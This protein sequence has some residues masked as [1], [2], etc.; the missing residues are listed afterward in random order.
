M[1]RYAR[2]LI[3]IVI[4]FGC[5]K[6]SVNPVIQNPTS[7]ILRKETWTGPT[8]NGESFAYFYNSS[9]LVERIERYQWGTYSANGGPTQTWFDTAYYTFEYQNG[10]CAKWSM[11]EGGACG[12]LVYEYNKRNLPVKR[13]LYYCNNVPESFTFYKYDNA[14]K[15]IERVDSSTAVD[16]RY[17]FTY[18]SETNLVAAICYILWSSPQQKMKYDWSN[19]DGKVNFIKAVNGLPPTF[20]WDNDF[21]SYSSSSPNN[22]QSEN[23]FTPVSINDSFGSPNSTN[24]SYQYNDAGLPVKM[25]SGPWTVSFEYEKYK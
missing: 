2:F 24:Y 9:H 16:F 13:T 6:D 12:F 1:S 22:S 7:Y 17:T 20:V 8:T 14:D 18:N 11:N 4:C 3:I 10:L 21:H 15:L 23:Y 5:R 19:F 25:V